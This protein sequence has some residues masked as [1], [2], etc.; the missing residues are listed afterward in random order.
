[1][2]PMAVVGHRRARNRH[3]IAAMV[4]SEVV[5]VPRSKHPRD[6]TSRGNCSSVHRTSGCLA[7]ALQVDSQTFSALVTMVA[8]GR[9][10]DGFTP[11]TRSEGHAWSAMRPS[12]PV[13]TPGRRMRARSV[14]SGTVIARRGRST[15]GSNGR[16]RAPSSTKPPPYR[17]HGEL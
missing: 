8:N 15:D 17:G 12:V 5:S 6:R 11:T 1:M 14:A 13:V 16:R 10:D 2:A 7:V 4:S 3:R 9:L